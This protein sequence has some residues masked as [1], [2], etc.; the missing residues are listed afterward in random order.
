MHALHNMA[1]VSPRPC[2]PSSAPPRLVCAYVE[3]SLRR[4]RQVWWC[5][6]RAHACCVLCI[7]CRKSFPND[8]REA[9]VHPALLPDLGS[10]HNT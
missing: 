10:L 5:F 8:Y 6:L 7:S 2:P 9:G 1:Q 3:P 4:C